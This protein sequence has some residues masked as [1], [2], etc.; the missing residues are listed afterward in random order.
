MGLI[1]ASILVYSG[2]TEQSTTHTGDFT[3]RPNDNWLIPVEEVFDGGPG[4]DGIPSI[5]NP[6]FKPLHEVNYLLDDDLVVGIKIGD[7]IR[8]YPHPILDWHEIVNDEID[9]KQF[10]VTYCPLTGSAITWDRV[11]EGN[12][13]T[14]GVS[15]LL[16]NSNLIAYDRATDS[17]W[18]QML[19][20]AVHG[21]RIEKFVDLIPIIETSWTTWKELYP[22]SK[23]LSR[24]TGFSRQYG[25]YPYGDYR[26]SE[27]LIFPVSNDD[28]RL[29]RKARVIGTLGKGD[30]RVFEIDK[31]PDTLHTVND[32]FLNVPYVT[33]GS[34][35][36]NII[37]SYKRK[38]ED[39]TVLEFKPVQNRLP[40]IMEDQEGT[41]WDVFGS[42]V[43][44]P[45]TGTQLEHTNGYIAYWFAWAAFYPNTTIHTP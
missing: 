26:E 13:T 9:G 39:G 34:S 19:L 43:E 45:R 44:G 33:I 5:D 17:Y 35:G 29:H 20:Q 16:Y 2:C 3:P 6:K 28:R 38:L 10:S 27:R 42:A 31:F 37:A 24:E 23:V 15:G 4:K 21:P 1:A 8:A 18:S 14:F 32:T 36:L 22:D 30:R 40:V 41:K 12:R 11:I 25:N 7:E